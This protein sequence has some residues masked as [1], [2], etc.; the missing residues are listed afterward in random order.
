[1]IKYGGLPWAD[2]HVTQNCSVA[3]CADRIAPKS[4]SDC[5]KYGYQFV[6][7]HIWNMAFPAPIFMELRNRQGISVDV[8]YRILFRLD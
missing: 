5:E 6:Y 2:F 1:M 8:L 7:A 4:D 3:F